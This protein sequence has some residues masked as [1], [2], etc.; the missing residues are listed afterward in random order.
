[1]NKSLSPVRF[2]LFLF[3]LVMHKQSLLSFCLVCKKLVSHI[4]I[5]VVEWS[6]ALASQYSLASSNDSLS[7]RL[8]FTVVFATINDFSECTNLIEISIKE[9]VMLASWRKP[10]HFLISHELKYANN[11]LAK[12]FWPCQ[13]CSLDDENVWSSMSH[14]NSS[15]F[16]LLMFVSFS[17]VCYTECFVL[18]LWHNQSQQYYIHLAPIKL[19][20][21][22]LALLLNY[23]TLLFSQHFALT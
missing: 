13:I 14:M 11:W 21:E 22:H 8:N 2:L 20:E 4:H 23:T 17:F 9:C 19:C 16:L 7:L 12:P 3:S 18:L 5:A 15:M 1:M 6:K 10:K